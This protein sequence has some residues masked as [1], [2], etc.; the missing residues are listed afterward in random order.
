MFIPS[1]ARGFTGRLISVNDREGDAWASLADAITQGHE[2]LTRAA[3]DRRLVGGGTLYRHLRRRPQAA[4]RTLTLHARDAQGRVSTRQATVEVRWDRVTLRP[5]E[6]DPW[7][8]PTPLSV[9][10]IELYEAYPPPGAV[11]FHSRLLSTCRTETLAD[12]QAQNLWYPDRWAVEVG[13][14]VVKNALNFEDLPLHDVAACERAL[15]LAGPVAAQV[16]RWVALARPSPP[17][18]VTTVFAPETLKDLAQYSRFVGVKVPAVWTVPGVV[19]VLGQ[20]GGGDVRRDRPAG[21]RVVVRG[22]QRF[23]AFR[24][25]RTF[26]DEEARTNA[27]PLKPKRTEPKGGP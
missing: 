4:T 11:R 3:Q 24:A 22:W 17:P 5:P 12:V 16:A 13:N 8:S 15:A 21:W 2:L 23:D 20:M 14:D 6:H 1:R 19:R 18:P 9:V 7:A 26:L 27:A 10:A 25:L